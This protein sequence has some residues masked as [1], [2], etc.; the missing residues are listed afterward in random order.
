[1]TPCNQRRDSR[2]PATSLEWR[3][4]VSDSTLHSPD[5]GDALSPNGATGSV[6]PDEE[7][8]PSCPTCNRRLVIL[9]THWNRDDE[10]RPVRRQLWGCPRGHATAYRQAGTFSPAE[11]MPNVAV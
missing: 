2:D 8:P 5:T 11:M 10:G 4:P 6:I 7:R 1:V 3:S 9:A